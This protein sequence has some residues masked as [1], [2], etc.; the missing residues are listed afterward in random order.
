MQSKQK[1]EQPENIKRVIGFIED[2]FC[3]PLDLENLAQTAKLS[4]FHFC[5]E[6]KRHVGINP[7]KYVKTQRIE[8]AKKLLKKRD[9]SVSWVASEVG[10]RDLSNFI[11]QFKKSTGL[12]PRV[13]RYAQGAEISEA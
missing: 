12:T 2:N 3:S 7:M 13:Y 11:R 4:K 10:F 1:M 5:R 9:L 6:F 8:K